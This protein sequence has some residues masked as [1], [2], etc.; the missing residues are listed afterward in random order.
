MWVTDQGMAFLDVHRRIECQNESQKGED[1]FIECIQL[2]AKS[3][4]GR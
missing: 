3:C 1:G 4:M 2:N